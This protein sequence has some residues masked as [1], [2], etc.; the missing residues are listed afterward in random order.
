M[1]ENRH[2]FNGELKNIKVKDLRILNDESVKVNDLNGRMNIINKKIDEVQGFLEEYYSGKS[3]GNNDFFKTSLNCSDGLSENNAVCRMIEGWANYLLGSDE[4]RE[5]RNNNRTQ[6]R[7]YVDET[8]FKLRT[9]KE[10]SLD[11]KIKHTNKKLDANNENDNVIID[12]LIKKQENKKKIKGTTVSKSDLVVGDYC[13]NVLKEYYQLLDYA[14]MAIKD[15][16]INSQ[17]KY[18]GKR[19]KFTKLKKDVTYDMIY[20]KNS[21]RGIFG[22]K[23]K[24]LLHDSTVPCW[25]EFDWYE[26]SHIK[27]LLYVIKDFNPQD[28]ISMLAFSLDNLL[29]QLFKINLFSKQEEK[30]II[31]LRKGYKNREISKQLNITD[32]KVSRIVNRICRKICEYILCNWKIEC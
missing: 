28:E 3:H 27:A 19:Y 15:I 30:V 8:E 6:Y 10:E 31:Y 2:L 7:F 17:S 11:G 1:F 26:E 13:S 14:D 16:K 9:L 24:N 23:P 18:R 32:V 29:E 22:E 5:E 4:V 21:L 12:F 20:C 25:E